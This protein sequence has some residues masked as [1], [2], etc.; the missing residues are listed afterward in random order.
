ME[1]GVVLQTNPPARQVVELAQF[2]EAC[3][4]DSVWTFDSC[5]LWQEPFVIYSQILA[6][7]ERVTVGP[8]VT[9]PLTRDW[10]VTA[11]LFATLNEMFGNRT[12]CAIGRGDSSLRVIGRRPS[13]M[14]DLLTA[15]EAIRALAE[16]REVTLNGTRVHL[17]W[18]RNSELPMWLA[19]MG[20]QALDLIGANAD[21]LVLGIAD[22]EFVSWAMS[23]V[24]A[25][26]ARAG[27]KPDEI[28]VCLAAPAYV[29]DDLAHQRDELRWYGGMVGNHVAELVVRYGRGGHGL[30]S[31]LTD[32]IEKRRGYDY[33]YHGKADNPSVGFVPDDVVERFCILGPPQQHVERLG[34][35]INAGV[36]HFALQLM[37]DAKEA[38]LTAYRDLVIPELRSVHLYS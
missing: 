38:T 26:A 9:N 3:G 16:G 35:L 22:P 21:G 37:H 36:G 24:R 12:R 13:S 29:G 15:S 31:S 32:Y 19:G 25:A 17:P 8:M 11:S 33:A 18:V 10:T 4:F 2:A 20:P 5:V 28:T 1:F 6:A 7:T 30:P 34:S 23:R 14:T 27:R